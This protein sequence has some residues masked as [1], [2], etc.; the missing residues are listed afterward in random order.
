M[1]ARSTKPVPNRSPE[2]GGARFTRTFIHGAYDGQINF[3]EPMIRRESMVKNPIATKGALPQAAGLN[4]W[5]KA[6]KVRE[7][8]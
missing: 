5:V 1:Y 8:H 7:R 2:F 6:P 4:R 3:L